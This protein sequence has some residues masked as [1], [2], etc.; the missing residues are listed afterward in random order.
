LLASSAKRFSK[1][2]EG[3]EVAAM[4]LRQGFPSCTAFNIVFAQATKEAQGDKTITQLMVNTNI[5]ST[6]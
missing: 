3:K 1:D 4:K 2:S 5:D 6:I